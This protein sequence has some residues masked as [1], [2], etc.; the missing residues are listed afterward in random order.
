MTT[1]ADSAWWHPWM[2]PRLVS[3]AIANRPGALLRLSH[4]CTAIARIRATDAS[5]SDAAEGLAGIAR[6]LRRL[7]TE[8]R[9][10]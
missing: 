2:P 8:Q 1:M 9:T 5:S 4:A 6:R 3:A 7:A 10:L